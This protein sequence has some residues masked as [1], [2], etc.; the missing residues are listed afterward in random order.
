MSAETPP[1]F[2]HDAVIALQS[3]PWADD[4]PGIRARET[5][6]DGRRW[7]IVEY[8]PRARREEWCRDGHAGFV[9]AGE[10]EY[11]F[12]DGQPPIV[13]SEGDAFTLATGRG[14]R[15]RNTRGSSARLF[16][17]DDPEA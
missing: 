6:V 11:E 10:V 12:A 3:T 4:V 7:A 9:L 14:H 17:I 8:E 2:I 15:G 16:L 13:V 5:H 1:P